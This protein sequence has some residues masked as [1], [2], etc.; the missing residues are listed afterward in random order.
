MADLF[1]S[2]AETIISPGQDMGLAGYGVRARH[3]FANSGI[4]DHLL[5]QALCLASKDSKFLLLALDL[6]LIDPEDADWLRDQLAQKTGLGKEDILLCLSHTH[7]GPVLQKK[8]LADKELALVQEYLAWLAVQLGTISAQAVAIDQQEGYKARLSTAT[9][10]ARLAYNRRLEKEDGSLEMLFTSWLGEKKDP[11]GP[12]DSDIPILL[13]ERVATASQDPYLAAPGLERLVLF[14]VPIHPVVMGPENRYVSAD[15]PGAARRCIEKT[16]GPG[17]KAIFLLGASGNI[18]PLIAC[19]NNF[20]ALDII[21]GAV[22]RGVCAALAWR[23]PLEFSRLAQVSSAL[24]AGS[25]PDLVRLQAVQLGQVALAAV[26]RENFFQLGQQVRQGS[27]FLQTLFI[28][29]TNGGSGYIPTSRDRQLDLGYEVASARERG[30]HPDLK[31]QLARALLAH[32]DS[33]AGS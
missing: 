22:G 19:Q 18:N 21:G 25:G 5:A 9:F 14:N 7:A 23:Q 6:C 27:P 28:S 10:S 33:L 2:Y 20:A 30:F 4:H 31:D 8:G 24:P 29:N 1:F 26:G 15:Y 3:G 32:L 13:L 16:L 11:T 12:V 17:T